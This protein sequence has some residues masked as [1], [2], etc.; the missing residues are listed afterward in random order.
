VVRQRGAGVRTGYSQLFTPLKTPVVSA[1][2]SN[3]EN[4]NVSNVRDRKDMGHGRSKPEGD[5]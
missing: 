3:D 2:C 1:S 5:E 4:E